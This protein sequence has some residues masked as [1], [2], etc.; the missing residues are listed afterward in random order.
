MHEPCSKPTAQQ[1]RY[2]LQRLCVCVCVLSRRRVQ[3]CCSDP[4]G[5]RWIWCLMLQLARWQAVYC[6]LCV[7]LCVSACDWRFF[8]HRQ[9]N[10]YCCISVCFH[11]THTHLLERQK[12]PTTSSR[13]G[14]ISRS[15]I[16]SIKHVRSAM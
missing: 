6:Q 15:N 9:K 11:Y 14:F 2:R 7:C 12:T 16:Q 4:V 8:T 5:F 3:A 13:E 10:T 1:L